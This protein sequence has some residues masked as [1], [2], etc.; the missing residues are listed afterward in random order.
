MA[1]SVIEKLG[2]SPAV[3]GALVLGRPAGLE[4]IPAELPAPPDGPAPF[5]LA[6]VDRIA[7][8]GP[9]AAAVLPRYPAAGG[10]LWFAYPK[11]TGAIRTDLSRDRGWEAL[12]EAGLLPVA[13][14]A[15]DATW[16]ALRFR[17]REEI[18][19]LTRKGA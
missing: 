7:A 2:W 8:V 1:R 18:P 19:R 14:V 3:R 16:S 4:A 12:T 11:R 15:L 6:F 17:R 13:Q 10:L 9:A 5:I